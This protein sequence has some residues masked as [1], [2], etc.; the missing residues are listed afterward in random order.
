MLSM[1]HISPKHIHTHRQAQSLYSA[2]HILYWINNGFLFSFASVY[3]QSFGFTTGQI[4]LVLGF[5]YTVSVFLQPAIVAVLERFR[6]RLNTGLVGVYLII[7]L[8]ALVLLVLPLPNAAVACVMVLALALQSAALPSISSLAHAMDAYGLEVDFSSARA[9]G[10]V[11]YAIFTSIMGRVLS[12]ISPRLLPA[13]YLCTLLA[14]A[15]LLC[16]MQTPACERREKQKRSSSSIWSCVPFVL[17]MAGV[18]SICLNHTMIDAFMLQ[19]L[20]NVGGGSGELGVAIA[21]AAILEVPVM[22]FYSRI[23]K[24]LGVR[25]ILLVCGWGW[26]VKN[27]LTAF[28]PSP[29]MIYAA[30]TLQALGYALYVPLT[31]DL[32]LKLLPEK[33]FLR[34]Q[35]LAGSAFT[36]GGLF[37]TFA[38]G[39]TLDALGVS[40]ALRLMTLFSLIGAVLFTVTALSKPLRKAE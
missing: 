23:R 37:A 17:F 2:I 24:A 1:T 18:L 10:S 33:D 19:I 15:A 22:L 32:V 12:R 36:L 14:M 3:L 29:V 40:S 31:I 20:Q 30:Q 4:G 26:F 39:V 21:I 6:L 38:G 27:A 11:G 25:T 9:L 16:L 28:A 7:A 34:G 35:A 5:A 8:L 13:M